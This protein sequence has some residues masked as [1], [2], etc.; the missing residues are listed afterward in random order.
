MKKIR[1]RQCLTVPDVGGRSLARYRLVY[2][3]I[4]NSRISSFDFQES[5]LPKCS[6]M[7]LESM[8][9]N[10]CQDFT[11]RLRLS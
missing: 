10:P 7:D 2:V 11:S 5:W 4:L 9:Q 6:Y 3:N 1:E 8:S